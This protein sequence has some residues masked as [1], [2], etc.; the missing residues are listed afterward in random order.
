MHMDERHGYSQ[1]LPL[2]WFRSPEER[3]RTLLLEYVRGILYSLS[4][5]DDGH[6]EAVHVSRIQHPFKRLGAPGLYK[7]GL[8]LLEILREAEPLFGGYWLPTPF[9]VIEI[10]KEFM[11]VGIVPNAYKLLGKVR[12]EGLARF[13]APDVADHFPRQTLE[14]WMGGGPQ[15]TSAII[16]AF[17]TRHAQTAVKT[18]SLSGVEFLT[19]TP[20]STERHRPFRWGSMP[21]EALPSERIAICRQSHH[22]HTRYFSASVRKGHI[23]SEAPIDAEISRLLFAVARHADMPVRAVIRSSPRG[24]EFTLDERLPIE[25]FRIALV[26]SREIIRAG[27]STTFILSPKLA[28]AFFT[29]LA[30]L[31][32]SLETLQ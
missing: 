21:V 7:V 32:C 8:R 5:R 31:G 17:S 13:L 12:N 15:D 19:I 2:E 25:E 23:A 1:S 27:R 18:S 14:G 22:G 20:G 4:Q 24:T 29:R 10:E 11:F 6:F 9:R 3:D 30:A 16:T 28:P 26:L